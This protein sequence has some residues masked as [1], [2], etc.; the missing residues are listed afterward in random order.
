MYTILL[1]QLF[2]NVKHKLIFEK[3][4]WM[5]NKFIAQLKSL[6]ISRGG[7]ISLR[8]GRKIEKCIYKCPHLH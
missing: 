8:G 2:I 1:T 4:T 3:Q 7:L 6:K 5:A